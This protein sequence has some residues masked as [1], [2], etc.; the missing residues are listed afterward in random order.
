MGQIEVF[1]F[2]AVALAAYQLWVSIRLFRA[3]QYE[4][5]QQW[6]QLAFIW[7]IPAVGAIAVHSMLWSDGRPPYKPVV[8][9]TEPGD[10]AS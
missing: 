2:L 10:N 1:I 7:L 6:F 8:G 3:P 9:Y 4:K 5:R